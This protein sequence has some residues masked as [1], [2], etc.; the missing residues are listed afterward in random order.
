MNNAKLLSEQ[1]KGLQAAI[2]SLPDDTAVKTLCRSF[3]DDAVSVL[4]ELQ[5][6]HP[7]AYE[8]S[9]QLALYLSNVA[10]CLSAHYASVIDE[11]IKKA[12]ENRRI[13]NAITEL[14]ADVAR[15]KAAAF[16][17]ADFS[18]KEF[19]VEDVSKQVHDIMLRE[20]FSKESARGIPLSKDTVRRWI[21]PSAPEYARHPGRR[22][23]LD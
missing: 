22:K 12:G 5:N 10:N 18:R 13:A 20:G 19:S 7:V 2:D 8:H 21:A 4:S 23:S 15:A 17:D 1:L 9:E 14:Y 11:Q 6:G 3:L 16:W